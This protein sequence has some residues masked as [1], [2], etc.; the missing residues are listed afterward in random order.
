VIKRRSAGWFSPLDKPAEAE[1]QLESQEGKRHHWKMCAKFIIVGSSKEQLPPAFEG[2]IRAR[3]TFVKPC[4]KMYFY[5][6]IK[7]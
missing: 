4:L 7:P 3:L 2:I 5:K 6:K 1:V